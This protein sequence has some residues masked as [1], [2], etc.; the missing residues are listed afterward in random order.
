MTVPELQE[1]RDD[2]CPYIV[3]TTAANF[4]PNGTFPDVSVGQFTFN[5][6]S[7]QIAFS[8]LAGAPSL[9]WTEVMREVLPTAVAEPNSGYESCSRYQRLCPTAAVHRAAL[10]FVPA[11]GSHAVGI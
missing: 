8:A 7:V 3:A 6:D 9:R 2:I 1:Y 4:G 10:T 5:A 11:V